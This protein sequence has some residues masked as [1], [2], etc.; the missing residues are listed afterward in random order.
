MT[1]IQLEQMREQ[2]GLTIEQMKLLAAIQDRMAGGQ[3]RGGGGG[4]SALTSGG[5]HIT[6]FPTG[7]DNTS[8]TGSAYTNYNSWTPSWNPGSLYSGSGVNPSLFGVP[9]QDP[10]ALNNSFAPTIENAGQF[11]SAPNYWQ[12]GIPG[13]EGGYNLPTSQEEF[14]WYTGG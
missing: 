13:T 3:G 4:G 9:N 11:P 6:P 8:G 1:Q 7:E 2:H 12:G 5:S 10:S 14:D